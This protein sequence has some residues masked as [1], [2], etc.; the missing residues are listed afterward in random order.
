MGGAW[1]LIGNMHFFSHLIGWFLK[2]IAI[3]D[4]YMVWVL[5]L[6]WEVLEWGV[7]HW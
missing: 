6:F 3:R 1:P 5:S 4:W 7:M 2:M